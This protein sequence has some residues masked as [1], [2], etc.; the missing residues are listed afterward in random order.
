MPIQGISMKSLR[1]SVKN[2]IAS[3]FYRAGG[4]FVLLFLM[5]GQSGQEAVQASFL[6]LAAASL[7]A[8][9]Y[10]SNRRVPQAVFVDPQR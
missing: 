3:H 5:A 7:I 4:V 6:I 2:S 1:K 8:A 10:W 9:E